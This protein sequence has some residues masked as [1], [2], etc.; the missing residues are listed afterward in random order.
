VN[1]GYHAAWAAW[2][3]AFGLIEGRAVRRGGVCLTHIID[4][5]PLPGVVVAWLWAGHHFV[6]RR[7]FPP[8]GG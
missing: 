4:R 3:A 1:R 7:L 2:V 6:W 5:L 8:S